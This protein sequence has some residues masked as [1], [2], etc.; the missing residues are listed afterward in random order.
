[1][2]KNFIELIQ[3]HPDRIGE[4]LALTVNF[5]A[6]IADGEFDITLRPARTNRTNQHW[7]VELVQDDAVK[8]T[9][10]AVFGVRTLAPGGDDMKYRYMRLI[11]VASNT[12]H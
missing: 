2:S 5:A 4:P 12:S 1:M 11:Y 9:A 6:P 3:Q 10:T 7:I 8:T